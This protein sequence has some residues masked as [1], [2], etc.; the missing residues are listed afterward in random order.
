MQHALR[1]LRRGLGAALVSLSL[2]PALAGAQ[3]MP[4]QA[5]MQAQW[6]RL[7][8]AAWIA[9]GAAQPRHVLYVFFDPNC[10]YCHRLWENLQSR[11]RKQRVQVRFILVGFITRTSPTKAAAILEADDPLQALRK[12]E[13]DWG[14][15][16]DGDRGG[17]IRAL[18]HLD[19]SMRLK[20]GMNGRLARDF[21][22]QGTPGLVWKD[23]RGQVYVLQSSPPPEDLARIIESAT[24]E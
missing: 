11:Y 22:I 24:A 20:L 19:F 14:K 18:R 3:G 13:R 2:L 21:G 17:G 8:T 10:G 23:R 4:S 15:N 7:A 6:P 12:N 5:M 9:D 16:P 1:T